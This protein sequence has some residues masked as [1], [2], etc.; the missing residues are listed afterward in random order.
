MRRF[1]SGDITP[2]ADS[3]LLSHIVSRGGVYAVRRAG[4]LT[5]AKTR[6]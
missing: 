3:S 6:R 2:R 4:S 5:S 1:F